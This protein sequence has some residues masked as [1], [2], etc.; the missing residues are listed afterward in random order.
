MRYVNKKQTQHKY[1]VVC[2]LN[3]IKLGFFCSGLF[4]GFL[5]SYSRFLYFLAFAGC[6]S[7]SFLVH[8]FLE[9]F[10]AA[11][12]V[13][14]FLFAGI[15]RMALIAKFHANSLHGAAG[16]EF[17]TASAYYFCVIV[18]FRMNFFL[19]KLLVISQQFVASSNY[20]LLTVNFFTFLSTR[21]ISLLG[22]V[23]N[24]QSPLFIDNICIQCYYHQ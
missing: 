4:G 24:C 19:H 9:F 13:H 23:V 15:K 22:W 14:K 10:Y 21:S 1:I 5:Y 20:W 16:N 2:F 18:I 7:G 11:G 6:V 3:L 8:A 17:I 12:S